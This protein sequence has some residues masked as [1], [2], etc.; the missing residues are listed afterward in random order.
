[1]NPFAVAAAQLAVCRQMMGLLA[2]LSTS[3][4]GEERPDVRCLAAV[5]AK[6]R[7]GFSGIL[8]SRLTQ[9]SLLDVLC[10]GQQRNRPWVGL[11][12]RMAC[13]TCFAPFCSEVVRLYVLTLPAAQVQ[14][15]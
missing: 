12:W 4:G 6:V 3:V 15:S 1:V 11:P 5:R 8:Q 13:L 14:T 10:S 7:D 9:M 2:V